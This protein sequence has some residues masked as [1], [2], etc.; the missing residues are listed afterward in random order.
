[1]NIQIRDK[2]FTPGAHANKKMKYFVLVLGSR[3]PPLFRTIEIVSIV[4]T[5]F[6]IFLKGERY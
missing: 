3:L 6:V 1:M 5:V 4:I 2:F